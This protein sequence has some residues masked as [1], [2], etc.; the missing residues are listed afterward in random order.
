MTDM[1]LQEFSESPTE[2]KQV[3]EDFEEIAEG[4]ANDG[5]KAKDLPSCD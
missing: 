5:A 2:P 3:L 1:L 4:T